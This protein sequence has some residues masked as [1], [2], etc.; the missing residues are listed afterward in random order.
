MELAR[1]AKNYVHYVWNG[2][3]IEDEIKETTDKGTIYWDGW[4]QERPGHY[5]KQCS[6][7]ANAQEIRIQD[8]NSS[9]GGNKVGG[10]AFERDVW[11]ASSL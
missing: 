2:L 8:D 7:K 11:L 5:W 1:E 10:G 3:E 9:F 4:S 6:R